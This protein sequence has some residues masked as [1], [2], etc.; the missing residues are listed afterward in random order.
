MK[1]S[2]TTLACPDW[3]WEKVLA[4]ASR[5]GY[6]GIELRIVDGEMNLSRAKPFLPENMNQTLQN[7]KQNRLEICCIDTSC[8]F[9][10]ISR[11]NTMIEEGKASIDLAAALN[12]PYI[13][14]FGD[15]IP[16]PTKEDETIE[17]VAKGL[18]ILGQYAEDKAVQVLLEVHSDFSVSDR[19][20]AVLER[21]QSKAIGVLWDINNPYKYAGESMQETYN[22]LGDYIKHTHIKD[23]LGMGKNERL[24][25]P[26]E[27]DV[28]IKECVE[29]LKSVGY[30]GWL[31][32]EWEKKWHPA[33]EEP[34]VALP[35]YISYIKK[36]IE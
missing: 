12:S 10:D 1:I 36:L 5:L 27:G 2:F 9:H 4:E 7:I 23:S 29:I 28:P 15:A 31:S 16:D 11:F 18:N 3:N 30:D 17:L 6:D 26:G 22:K 14:V 24:V 13:R 21:T 32:F 35:C 8:S 33:I 25:L 20:L 34:E 19:V